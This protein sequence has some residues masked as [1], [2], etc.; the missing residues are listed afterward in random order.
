MEQKILEE[1]SLTDKNYRHYYKYKHCTK[2]TDWLNTA[3][4]T[5]RGNGLFPLSLSHFICVKSIQESVFTD[6]CYTADILHIT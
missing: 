6:N 2:E 1:L 5:E 4:S 3:L